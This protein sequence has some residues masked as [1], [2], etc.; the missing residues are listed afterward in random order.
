MSASLTVLCRCRKA[1][2]Q[3]GRKVAKAATGYW[4]CSSAWDAEGCF[5]QR[6]FARNAYIRGTRG[7]SNR[8]LLHRGRDAWPVFRLPHA[9]SSCS[10]FLMLVMLTAQQKSQNSNYVNPMSIYLTTYLP[11]CLLI[12]LT[13]SAHTYVYVYVCNCSHIHTYIHTYIL[14][15]I[16]TYYHTYTHTYKHAYIHAYIY[17]Y[18]LACMH[19]CP[20]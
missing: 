3:H 4:R 15:Y 13:N 10:W 8:R 14:A 1:F 19:A 20:T 17:T 11:I 6:Y 2:V 5:P 12:Y 7:L 9:A 16:H 18:L